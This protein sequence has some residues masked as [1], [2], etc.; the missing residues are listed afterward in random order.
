MS[1]RWVRRKIVSVTRYERTSDVIAMDAG[2]EESCRSVVAGSGTGFDVRSRVGN[3]CR[4]IEEFLDRE[5]GVERRESRR[6]NSSS[7]SWK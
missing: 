6:G 7:G 3:E 4:T 5:E 2:R 1:A